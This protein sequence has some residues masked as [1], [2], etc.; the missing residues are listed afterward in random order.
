[1]KLVKPSFEIIEM[2]DKDALYRKIELAA[3]VCY[4]SENRIGD[5]SAEKII[6]KIMNLGHLS[7]IEHGSFTVRFICNRGVTHELVRHRLGSYSQESTRYCNYGNGDVQFV[8]PVWNR[9]LFDMYTGDLSDIKDGD[10]TFYDKSGLIVL[11]EKDQRTFLDKSPEF[12]RDFDRACLWCD[13]VRCSEKIYKNMI[14]LGAKP[15]EARSV[16]DISVKTEIIMTANLRE[17]LHVFDMRTSE[18]AHPDIQYLMRGLSTEISK[19]YPEI[20]DP[21]KYDFSLSQ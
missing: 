4:K 12:I 14:A 15:Q 20:F 21:N 18:K 19:A 11:G 17:W 6:K 13:A 1:M 10:K 7:V 3:R 8:L 5:G 16:L 2:P 9:I